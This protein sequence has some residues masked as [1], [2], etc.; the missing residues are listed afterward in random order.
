MET[1]R[2]LTLHIREIRA[3]R[4]CPRKALSHGVLQAS[5]GA[6]VNNSG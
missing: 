4:G 5:T 6:L 2:K 1:H 3:I